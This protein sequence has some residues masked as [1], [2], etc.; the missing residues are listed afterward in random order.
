MAR[1]PNWKPED[2]EPGAREGLL[3]R[4]VRGI[5]ARLPSA[6]AGVRMLADPSNAGSVYV[7]DLITSGRGNLLPAKAP[8]PAPSA[9]SAPSEPIDWNP[10]PNRVPSPMDLPDSPGSGIAGTFSGRNGLRVITREQADAAENQGA[11]APIDTSDT[12][13]YRG[14]TRG[15][16][17]GIRSAT[18]DARRDATR[19]LRPGTD[20]DEIM[21]R[22][23]HATGSYFNKGFPGARNAQIA[24]LLGQL[25]AG[26]EVSAAGA[27]QEGDAEL[28]SAGAQFQ[29]GLEDRAAR[30][31]AALGLRGSGQ[32]GPDFGDM[33]NLMQ[34]DETRRA[35][36][37]RER[38]A[39][40]ARIQDR[41][42]SLFGDPTKDPTA[43]DRNNPLH[44][45][46]ANYT[47]LSEEDPN[48]ADT[49]EG[50]LL[51]R[52]ILNFATQEIDANTTLFSP[53]TGAGTQV[54]GAPTRLR[55]L[56]VDPNDDVGLR[57]LAPDFVQRWLGMVP[58]SAQFETETGDVAVA[59]L[60][61]IPALQHPVVQQALRELSAHYNRDR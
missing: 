40:T 6:R 17:Q 48:F 18:L 33:I 35:N 41:I 27:A 12:T 10:T 56:R 54:A 22:V 28:A 42:D 7:E 57:N 37:A 45:L 49:E 38:E 26:N 14:I 46:I 30:N 31:T 52:R 8:T 51:G 53:E 44:R 1:D 43:L 19:F 4:A 5:A 11:P 60:D 58:G 47:A 24:A 13:D 59:P 61:D 16:R 25:Q 2:Q 9:P 29:S 15:A 32:S 39:A 21:R 3:P 55:G 34:L 50:Q 23:Q 36:T 20:E